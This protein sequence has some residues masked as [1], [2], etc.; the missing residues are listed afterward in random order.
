[1]AASLV[2]LPI[3][4]KKEKQGFTFLGIEREVRIRAGPRSAD[5]LRILI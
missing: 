5:H 1:M 2:R 3:Q 4:G